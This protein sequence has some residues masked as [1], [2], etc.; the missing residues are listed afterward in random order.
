MSSF[1]DL[2]PRLQPWARE[3]Y[4][5][6]ERFGM[7]PRVTSTRRSVRQQAILFETRR[8]VLAGEL[9]ASA[10][11]FPVAAP[12]TSTHELGLAFDMVVHPEGA[13]QILGD[14]WRGWGGVWFASDDIHY[15]FGPNLLLN[16]PKIVTD[17]QIAMPFPE[18]RPG[19]LCR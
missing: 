14:V 5:L 2:D 9:P 11:P 15:Q 6:A 7:R 3:L 1:A 13:Q 4:L 16:R 10:Q 12:G 17:R 19:V 18:M 8:R